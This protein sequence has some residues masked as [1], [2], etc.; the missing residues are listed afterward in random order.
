MQIEGNLKTLVV[1]IS[2]TQRVC[3]LMH[4]CKPPII[5]HER[6]SE[7]E[8]YDLND[9][10]QLRHM[11]ITLKPHL[12]KADEYNHYP[13]CE[14]AIIECK[15]NSLRN[16]IEQLEYTATQLLSFDK[17]VHHA[18]IIASKIN[19]KEKEAF[20]KRGNVLYQKKNNKPVL[21]PAGSMKIPVNLYSP[22]EIEA[23][24]QKFGGTLDIWR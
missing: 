4:Q 22:M 20:T 2:L 8:R 7:N 6:P 5:E 21:I 15:G 10:A 19:H 16:S 9:P 13:H 1:S 23:Q 12:P 14:W 18:I 24:Y 3:R 17:K 11:G